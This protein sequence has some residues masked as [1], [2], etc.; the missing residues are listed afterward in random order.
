MPIAP[1]Y[2][3][4]YIEEEGW[5]CEIFVFGLHLEK[6]KSKADQVDAKQLKFL[7]IPVTDLRHKVDS[8]VLTKALKKWEPVSWSELPYSIDN[9]IDKLKKNIKCEQA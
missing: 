7:V 3:G 8:M 4:V 5:F 6:D 2:P 1:T 9:A